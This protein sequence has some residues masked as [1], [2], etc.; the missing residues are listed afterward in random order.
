VSE[1]VTR[2][3]TIHAPLS[4]VMEVISDLESTDRWANEAKAAKVQAHDDQGRPSRI[5]VTLGALRFTT[6]ATYD[7]SYTDNSV[8]LTCVDASLIREST[9]R[10]TAHDEG[11]GRVRL[12]MSSTMEVTVPG[13]P[14]WGLDR[15]MRSSA[16][17]NLESIRKDAE[18]GS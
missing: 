6:T 16:D 9:I 15:A 14:R 2:S 8:T 7:V 12:E 13:I 10:Y 1:P 3:V 5:A 17:K 18:S 11:D 4:R